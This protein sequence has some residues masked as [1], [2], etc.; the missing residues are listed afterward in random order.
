MS[1]V[2]G[3][4]A[5]RLAASVWLAAS[6]ASAAAA[7]WVGSWGADPTAGAGSMVAGQTVRQTV[8]LSLGGEALRLRLSNEPG[9]E[10]VAVGDVE[11]AE[12]GRVPGSI[13]PA[14][15]RAIT[16]GGRRSVTI[17]PGSSVV[18]D[19]APVRTLSL[20]SLVVSMFVTRAGRAVSVHPKGLSTA[21][22]HA[23]DVA[24]ALSVAGWRR[25]S[26]RW[27]L[28]EVDVEAADAGVVVALGDSIT[29]GYGSTADADR[30]WPDFLAERL[31]AAHVRLGV[32]DA[33]IAGNHV[34]SD[35]A[36]RYGVAA[37]KRL[38]RDVLSVPNGRMVIL[39]EGIN[40]VGGQH[41]TAAAL[42]AGMQRIVSR[43]HAG[44]LRVLGGTLTPFAGSILP[45]YG[46]DAGE[47]VRQT[48][49]RWIRTGGGFD[50]VVDF[51]AALRDPA[52]P[53]HLA[54]GFDSGDHLH[55]NDEGYRRMAEAVDLR[56]LTEK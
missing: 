44:G 9:S 18:S 14:S 41:A 45:G 34:L 8:R 37:A 55:P 46:N 20:A 17:A 23:G 3:R 50:G 40:D 54:T 10:A 19:G 21:F 51:D 49:N 27:L 30:R 53:T 25:S 12:P 38:E 42:I 32:V 33:G 35:G 16:F 4:A 1:R 52:R 24:G 28:T 13:E 36:A 6:P 2:V 5:A 11:V 7:D 48:V 56:L 43:A 15:A 26:S 39:L 29:D 47:A 31:A 22:L